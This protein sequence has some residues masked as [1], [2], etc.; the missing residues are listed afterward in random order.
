MTLLCG[1]CMHTQENVGH[2]LTSIGP[3]PQSRSKPTTRISMAQISHSVPL[4]DQLG[5]RFHETTARGYLVRVRDRR[6]MRDF[7]SGSDVDTFDGAGNGDS[8]TDD[9]GAGMWQRSGDR[10]RLCVGEEEGYQRRI[11]GLNKGKKT[12]DVTCVTQR[13][14]PCVGVKTASDIFRGRALV[15]IVHYHRI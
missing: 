6:C 9:D 13:P 14:H 4:P 11:A 1:V 5:F 3:L 7:L 2:G 15:A 8:K 12:F 10:D